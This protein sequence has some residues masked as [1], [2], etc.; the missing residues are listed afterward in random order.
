MQ[1]KFMSVMVQDQEAALAFYTGKLGFVKMADIPMGAYRWLTVI[2]HD[3]VEGVELVLEPMGF[4][5]ARDYQKALFEAGIPAIALVTRDIQVDYRRLKK[6]GV[7]FRGEP[8]HM[9]LISAVLFEDT[10]G[11]LINLVQPEIQP[12]S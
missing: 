11:N 9:G 12:A 2:S 1:L 8:K 10:C 7:V 3:G 5:P 4:P 6:L